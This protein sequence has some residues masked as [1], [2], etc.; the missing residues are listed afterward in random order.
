M[1]PI[2][3]TTPI[4]YAS[5]SPHLGHAYTTI[6][7]D[8][9]TRFFKL[10]GRETRFTTGTDEHGLKIERT[11]QKNGKAPKEF[12]DELAERFK[13]SWESLN[14]EYDDFIRTT[15]D[16]HKKV[17][18][19]IWKRMEDNGDIYL[20]KYE[21]LYCVECEQYYAEGELSEGSLCPIHGRK[22]ELMSEDTYFFRLSKYHDQL[23]NYIESHPNFIFPETRK[24]EVLGFLK[25]NKL[26]DLSISRTS[27]NWGIPVPG[28]DKHIIYVWID[29]LT[30]YISSLG[31]MGTEA[32]EKFWSNTIHIIGKDILRFHAVY[33][34]CML[35]SAGLPLPETLIVHGWWTISN[36]KISKSDPATKLDPVML[37]KDITTDAVKYFLLKEL[38]V[39]KDGD[40][41][42][43]AL[44]ACINMGLANNLGNLVSRTVSMAEKYLNGT[45]P[46][47][48]SKSSE[49]LDVELIEGAHKAAELVKEEMLAFNTSAAANAIL[50]F[51]DLLNLYIEKTLPWQ[52]AKQPETTGRLHQVLA[53]LLEAINWISNLGYP[54]FPEFAKHIKIRLGEAE[55]FTWPSE[56]IMPQRQV[57]QGEVLFKRI[58]KDDEKILIEK[59]TS[60]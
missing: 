21:G 18:Q 7:A 30:N 60:N 39:G 57:S 31:G 51:G 29:A 5:G 40:L 2:Y 11:A 35:M 58:S 8:C 43:E 27:F 10:I 22:V 42:Y 20:G 19:D 34:P 49:P 12:V 38:T 3:I 41:D 33:W 55:V 15:E 36:K 9:F 25:H 14:I 47:L 4:Y 53:H 50:S 1:K 23:L 17:A 56:F 28:S 48:E 16:R 44:I 46:A 52:L 54:F 37:S 59:W 6:L 26:Q 13:A 24:N 45:V 32:Y